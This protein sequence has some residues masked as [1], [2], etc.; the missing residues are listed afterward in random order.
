MNDYHREQLE[1]ILWVRDH[2]KRISRSDRVWLKRRIKNYLRFRKEVDQFLDR[3][4]SNL[5][6]EKCYQD[7]YSACCSREGITT[8]FADVFINGLVS[9]D[10]E[11]EKLVHVLSRPNVGMKCVYLGQ[12]GCLWVVKPIVCAMFLC[13]PARKAVFA[14]NSGAL[15]GWQG[16]KRRGKRYTWPNQPVLFDALETHCI[17]AGH[18]SSLMY[19]HNSP[20]L[21]RVK[22]VAMRK[23]QAA[24]QK[25]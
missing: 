4:F 16:L 10:E 20:G 12:Q 24:L 11:I 13:K 21:L 9:S 19:L 25:F 22:H 2:L 6:T 14:G 17:R 8:F 15:E 3:Y 7:H 5:C 1:A 23:K 18:A